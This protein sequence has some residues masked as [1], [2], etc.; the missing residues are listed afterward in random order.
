M[1]AKALCIVA[2]SS[3]VFLFYADAQITNPAVGTVMSWGLQAISY[4][5][6]GTSFTRIAAGRWHGLALKSNGAV[7]AWGDNSYGQSTVPA[8]LSAAVAVAGGEYHSLALKND[9]TVV[10]WGDDSAS[11]LEVPTGLSGVTAVA[12]GGYH[13]L[14]LRNDG[15]V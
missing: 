9:G 1:R 6:R 14:A 15:T 2:G 5:S 3:M 12:A 4:V 13:S 7:A 11:Q 8:D 10:A